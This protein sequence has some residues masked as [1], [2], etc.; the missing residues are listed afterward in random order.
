MYIGP[1]RDK[2]QREFEQNRFMN[3]IDGLAAANA[4]SF[5]S[6]LNT[7]TLRVADLATDRQWNVNETDAYATMLAAAI[8]SKLNLP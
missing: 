7:Q 5:Q 3:T 2:E 1:F 6:A 8:A 4:Q